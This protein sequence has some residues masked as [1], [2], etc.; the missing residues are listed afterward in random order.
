MVQ[1]RLSHVSLLLGLLLNCGL[2][3]SLDDGTRRCYKPSSGEAAIIPETYCSK[4]GLISI[5]DKVLVEVIIEGIAGR[6]VGSIVKVHLTLQKLTRGVMEL[7]VL[8]QLLVEWL[9]PHLLL[10]VVVYELCARHL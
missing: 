1:V 3:L 4:P 9:Q 7:D 8:L 2:G 5:A 6:V 10:L